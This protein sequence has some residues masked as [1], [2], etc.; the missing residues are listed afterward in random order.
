M[1]NPSNFATHLGY[2]YLSGEATEKQISLFPLP[3]ELSLWPKF[4]ELC[5]AENV[6][7]SISTPAALAHAALARSVL[8]CFSASDFVDGFKISII[9]SWIA[10]DYI[11]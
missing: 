10:L 7:D 6:K 3:S 4:T 2:N 11:S 8:E 5:W 9:K 1:L